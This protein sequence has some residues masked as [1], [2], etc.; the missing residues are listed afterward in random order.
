M[1]TQSLMLDSL[2]DSSFTVFTNSIYI[3]DYFLPTPQLTDGTQSPAN[4]PSTAI[5]PCHEGT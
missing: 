5:F 1:N 4:V 3:H 2:A